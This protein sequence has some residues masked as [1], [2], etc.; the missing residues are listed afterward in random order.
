MKNIKI[1][2]TLILLFCNIYL[3]A[4]DTEKVR[5]ETML[6]KI[7]AKDRE[8]LANSSKCELIIMGK[9]VNKSFSY[10]EIVNGKKKICTSRTI[11]VLKIVK[12]ES[13]LQTIEVYFGQGGQIVTE[14]DGEIVDID[15]APAVVEDHDENYIPATHGSFTDTGYFCLQKIT[16]TRLNAEKQNE[17]VEVYKPVDMI[18]I[19]NYGSELNF[20]AQY[21]QLSFS[22]VAALHEAMNLP[23]EKSKVHKK[24]AQTETI[25]HNDRNRK[26]FHQSEQRISEKRAQWVNNNSP[27]QLGEAECKD[28]FF[29]EVTNG[30]GTNKALEIFNPR[31]AS[32]DLTGFKIKV[33]LLG[34]PL[35]IDVSL[36][37][38]IQAKGTYVIS[39]VNADTTI[40][41]IANRIIS[42]ST[43]ISA[44]EITLEDSFGT[45]YDKIG[46]KQFSQWINLSIPYYQS[47]SFKRKYAVDKG[48]TSWVSGQQTWDSIAQNNFTNLH[49]HKNVCAPLSYDVN[50]EF[51]NFMTS[52]SGGNNY[53]EFD[54]MATSPSGIYLENAPFYVG[55]DNPA[56]GTN[57]VGNNSITVTRGATFGVSYEDPQTVIFDSLA[58]MF[59]V[60]IS[61]DINAT[62]WNRPYISTTPVQVLHF[63]IKLINC[64][65]NVDFNFLEQAATAFVT[66]GCPTATEDALLG[67]YY[68]VDN[69]FYTNLSNAN[70][71]ACGIFISQ[72]N[73]ST[74][75]IT[76]HAGDINNPATKLV[77][78]GSEFGATPGK[79]RMRS[80]GDGGA[81]WV[82]LDNYDIVSWSDNEII[83]KVPNTMFYDTLN[84][85]IS[86]EV[87][88]G[89]IRIINSSGDSTLTSPSVDVLY[90]LVNYRAL[91]GANPQFKNRRVLSGLEG[92]EHKIRFQIS[93]Q[94]NQVPGARDCIAKAIKDWRCSTA[95]NWYLDSVTTNVN[96]ISH[97]SI[98]VI[99]IE[100]LTNF[101]T[102]A[103]T[104]RHTKFCLGTGGLT[105]QISFM[106]DAD[107]IFN[108][109][110][111]NDFFFDTTFTQ[112]VPAGKY[113]FYNVILHELGHAILL[114]HTNDETDIMYYSVSSGV[115]A[116]QR[117][118]F[119]DWNN[120][121]GGID[122]VVKSSGTNYSNCNISGAM[123]I[124]PTGN[125]SGTSGQRQIIPQVDQ[126]L[127]VFPNPT[128]DL[129]N[130]SY[131]LNE[132]CRSQLQIFNT[133][134][135]IVKEIINDQLKGTYTL[136]LDTKL[137]ANGIYFIRFF[138]GKKSR[139]AKVIIQ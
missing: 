66:I 58:N 73:G 32:L 55:Y 123:T 96:T 91:N 3:F 135:Q 88:S 117:V 81:T 35:P 99:G 131:T 34:Q 12:G 122:V 137:F 1:F 121:D 119:I 84:P 93:D 69:V 41:A 97:D 139:Q 83:L 28:P 47:H 129:M 4:Q 23:F 26:N 89:E 62:S 42:D 17:T 68:F 50:F 111:L 85:A 20:I 10:Y 76:C 18:A 21:D 136:S 52:N 5:Q 65:L 133:T 105:N 115:P 43:L 24:K 128:N 70:V 30:T 25:N 95:V 118:C 36:S 71:P 126:T 108:L 134:G 19:K 59:V 100:S 107:I 2:N 87:G 16:I 78:S 90:T 29:S 54:I 77:I 116:N 33:Y 44:V 48:D 53:A 40:L 39:A 120:L 112:N 22:T 101:S 109:D 9:Q 132:N 67:N 13:S 110:R 49:R 45:V 11:Q 7:I 8:Q 64:G 127:F 74:T 94:L 86:H 79:V 60:R 46:S 138:D 37:G 57:V 98:C 106:N 27:K 82:T 104:Q 14:K 56:F 38:S 51:D 72:I 114:G 6:K 31:L 124:E 80:S 15:Y 61:D 125:C 130:I 103:S 75:N 92:V 102:L 113:D 63:K